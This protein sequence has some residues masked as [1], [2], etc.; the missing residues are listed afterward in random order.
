[1]NTGI[2]DAVNLGWKLATVLRGEENEVLLDSYNTERRRIGQ[3]LLQGTDKMF[4]FLATTNP[5]Y[6]FLR[7]YVLPF[8]MPWIMMIAGQRA[9]TY[10]F[11]SELGIRYRRSPIVG[12]ATTWKGALKG[13]DRVP[14]GRLMKGTTEVTVHSL[15]RACGHTLLLFSGVDARVTGIADLN[16]VENLFLK[17]ARQQFLVSKVVS[18]SSD[19]GDVVDSEGQVHK[20]FGFSTA[21][22]VLVR[23]DGYIAFIGPLTALDELL[24]W[25]KVRH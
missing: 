8:F 7:N 23:P 2:H 1:M 16:N 21:G 12:Q 17:R 18:R 14:D 25:E 22:F 10:R 19:S 15:L 20:L 13:G 11:T 3:I 6:L 4:E 24:L 9:R 5:F